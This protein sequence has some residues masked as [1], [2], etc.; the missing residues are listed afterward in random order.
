MQAGVLAFDQ[1]G[2]LVSSGGYVGIFLA[3]L[4]ENFIQVIPSEAIM[5]FAGFLVSEGKLDFFL[6]CLAGTLGTIVGTIPWYY[7]GRTVNQQKIERY[8]QRHG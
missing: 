5:P 2:N 6:T 4:I 3:M 1:I 7:I 8:V